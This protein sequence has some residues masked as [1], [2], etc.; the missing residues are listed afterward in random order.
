M[1][2]LGVL[3]KNCAVGTLCMFSQTSTLEIHVKRPN[4]SNRAISIINFEKPYLNFIVD[5]KN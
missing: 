4:F 3:K 5:T 1:F 2:C